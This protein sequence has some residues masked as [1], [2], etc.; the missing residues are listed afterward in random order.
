MSN[1][2]SFKQPVSDQFTVMVK[3]DRLFKTDVTKEDLWNTYLDSFPEGTNEV[4]KERREYDCVACKQFIRRCGNVVSIKRNKL[5]S[6]WDAEDLEFPFNIVAAKMSE[7]VKS[8]AIRDVFV[9]NEYHQGI[10]DNKQLLEDGTVK[11]WSHFYYKLP[12]KFV[13]S[14]SIGSVQGKHRDAKNVFERAMKELTLD[15]AETILDLI[16][17]GSLYKGDEFMYVI[18]E[19]VKLKNKYD[20][21]PVKNRDNW[22]WL[23]STGP[24]SRIRN[25]AIGTLLIN[26]SEDMDLNTAVKKFE[27]VVAPTN[28]KRPKAIFTKK[29]VEEAEK[30]IKD[31]GYENS[32]SRKHATLEDITI[33]NVIWKNGVAKKTNS[34]VFDDLKDE[35]VINPRKLDKVEEVSIKD[36]VEKIAP[37]AS[38]IEL[39]VESRHQSNLM[40]LIA[41]KD[42]N[43]PSMMK[44]SNNFTHSYVGNVTDSLREKVK[45]AGGRVDGVFRFTH[46]WNEIEPN[47]SLMDLHVFMPGNSHSNRKTH[48]TYGD[49]RRVGWNNRKDYESGGVQDVDYVNQAP[50][51]YIPVENIT[52][53]SLAKMPEGKYICKIHNWNYRVSGGRGKAEIEF[54]GNLF[55]YE[56]PKTNHHEWITIAE[57]TLKNGEFTIE[58]ELD[59]TSSSREVWG[60]NTNQFTKVS[61]LMFSPNFWDGQKGIGNKHYFFFLDD[62]KNDGQ[63]RGFYNE[64]LKDELIPHKRVFEAL[65]GKMRVEP[66]NNQLSGL[67]F[68]STQ[69]NNVIVKVEGSFKR[70]IKI[71]I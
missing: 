38:N 18:Q 59:S 53:P 65:G 36:F 62:C 66:S 67:G 48:N 15:A 43:A 69:R 4:H 13:I 1:F 57:V 7:L 14:D 39:M 25:S 30:T 26:L 41:P 3:E 28:Y 60:V 52:F 20:K 50:K 45:A 44:W 71:K 23:N 46:S 33:N 49:G 63:P 11:T 61:S 2:K 21:V 35:V 10:D 31:L 5:V 22:C 32:L 9:S 47:Q 55:Q 16:S 68:S 17:Q 56:Y 24:V 12:N 19:F 51:G 34:S 40:S 37:G 27:A 70:I 29:M 58:H 6:I 8:A 54:N 64:F 42:N